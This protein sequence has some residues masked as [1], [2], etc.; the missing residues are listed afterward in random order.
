[1]AKADLPRGGN[2]FPWPPKEVQDSY[3]NYGEWAAWYGGRPQDLTRFYA[4]YA[5]QDRTGFFDPATTAQPFTAVWRRM[6]FWARQQPGQVTR[7]RY[8]VPIAAD[9]SA[10]SA[11]QLFSD[12]PR[13][14]IPEAHLKKATRKSK[15]IQDRLDTLIDDDGIIAKFHEG[16]EIASALSGVFIQVHWDQ[17]F[18]D[19]PLLQVIHPD[20]AIPAFQWGV[21]SEVL[22]WRF[23]VNDGKDVWRH[24]ELHQPGVI[25]HGL[26]KGSAGFLGMPQPL[27][28]APETSMF[29]D[30]VNDQQEIATGLPGLDCVYVPNMRPNRYPRGTDLGRSDYQ[31][32]ESLM[33]ALDETMTSWM[34]DIR[35]GKARIFA[36]EEFVQSQGRGKGAIFDLEREVYELLKMTPQG[37]Q[38][39][40]TPSQ[41]AIRVAEHHAT[42]EALMGR[43]V[44]TAGYSALTFGL[45]EGSSA[46]QQERTATE[47][48]AREHRTLVTR[49]KKIR[50][51]LPAISEILETLLR[52]DAQV[53]GGPGFLRPR[54]DFPETVHDSLKDTAQAIQFLDAARAVTIKTKV[55]LAHPT[56]DP[57]EIQD[58]VDQLLLEQGIVKPGAIPV[59]TGSG[60]GPKP[61]APGQSPEPVVTPPIL[62]APPPGMA[63][64]TLP[65]T[66]TPNSQ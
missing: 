11:D 19:R 27:S 35:L 30:Q 34:R 45:G 29:A 66:T 23:V 52:V 62:G 57:D 49:G 12:E 44:A 65:P 16:A 58:E 41:F 43:I 32:T 1:M 47:V 38:A 20:S 60:P 22:F 55:E 15:D 51:W 17:D 61:P 37:N 31:G 13:I 48:M 24:L 40:I 10:T 21:L 33:D 39:V 4:G 42:A 64:T 63:G 46:M 18:K 25:T 5:G 2:N 59:I 7:G 3:V 54:P 56:W 53:F 14:L 6:F 36:P 50:Y 28:A 26:Y 8:H 9:M